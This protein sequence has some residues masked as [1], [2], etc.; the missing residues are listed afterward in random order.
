VTQPRFTTE[1]V[2]PPNVSDPLVLKTHLNRISAEAART[3]DRRRSEIDALDAVKV[4]VRHEEVFNSRKLPNIE[5][6]AFYYV[7][8]SRATV[9]LELPV[10]DE[11]AG[12][13][14]NIKLTKG[15]NAVTVRSPDSTI[16]GSPTLSI[17]IVNSSYWL[18][19][20]GTVW[21][22]H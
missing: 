20:T 22:I 5:H 3:D 8:A 11:N 12:K 21:Y 4:E 2:A 19:C 13:L 18:Y 15:P 10:V 17:T 7:D 1:V 14:I 16:D 9:V 6:W